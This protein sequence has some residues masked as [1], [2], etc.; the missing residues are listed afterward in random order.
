MAKRKPKMLLPTEE[1]FVGQLRK[2][3]N[4]TIKASIEQFTDGHK[5][6]C[7]PEQVGFKP[8]PKY[9]PIDLPENMVDEKAEK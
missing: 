9:V 3:K 1:Y 5:V 8:D 4:E 2:T 7:N 6:W